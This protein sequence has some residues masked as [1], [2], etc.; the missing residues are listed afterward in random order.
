MSNKASVESVL[1]KLDYLEKQIRKVGFAAF[2]K[3]F[4]CGILVSLVVRW[5]AVSS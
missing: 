1:Y 3:G 5:I 2:A 4:V